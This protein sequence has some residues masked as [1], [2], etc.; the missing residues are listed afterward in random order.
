MKVEKMVAKMA[1]MMVEQ[2]A[3]QMEYRWVAV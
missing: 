1:A 3:A 2:K